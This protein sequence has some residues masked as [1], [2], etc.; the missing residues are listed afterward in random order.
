M[1]YGWGGQPHAGGDGNNNSGNAG[2]NGA[3]FIF[4]Y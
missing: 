2:G 4:C 3:V 1:G